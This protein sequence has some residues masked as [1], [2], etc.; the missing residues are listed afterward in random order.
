MRDYQA[1]VLYRTKDGRECD[2]YTLVR[3]TNFPN[4]VS[5][6]LVKVS[7][8]ID[9]VVRSLG[10]EVESIRVIKCEELPPNSVE[11]ERTISNLS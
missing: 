6:A 8:S 9:E 1:A 4:A 10:E 3:A 2:V 5:L 7:Q 11:W